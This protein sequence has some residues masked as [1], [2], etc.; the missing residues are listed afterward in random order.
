MQH[1][2]VTMMC[3]RQSRAVLRRTQSYLAK[4]QKRQEVPAIS[5]DGIIPHF[6]EL[7]NR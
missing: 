7:V 6:G 5:S 4:I 3:F 2:T 1:G